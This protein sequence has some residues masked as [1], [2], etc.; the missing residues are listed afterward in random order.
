MALSS[1]AIS[2]SPTGSH[3]IDWRA[4]KYS[5]RFVCRREKYTPTPVSAARY[6]DDDRDVERREGGLHQGLRGVAR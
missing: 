6:D 4:R 3:A 1:A 5:S 2:D